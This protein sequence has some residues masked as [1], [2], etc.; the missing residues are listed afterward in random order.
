M[1]IHINESGKLFGYNTNFDLS[2]NTSLSLVFTAPD[3]SKIAIDPSRISA[4]A[5]DGIFDED[6]VPTTYLANQY[7]QFV[8]L[9]TDFLTS[10]GWYVCGT[11]TNAGVSPEH[12]FSARRKSFTVDKAC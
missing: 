12:I 11:Y 5:V 10:S 4:P 2:S 1:S 8:I 3:G 6:G 7:M 9:P